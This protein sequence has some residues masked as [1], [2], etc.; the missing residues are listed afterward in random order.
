MQ[1]LGT[2]RTF[3]RGYAL[4]LLTLGALL[5]AWH[6]LSQPPP[7]YAQIPDSGAQR[8]RMIQ[9]LVAANQKLALSVDLLKQIRDNT[10]PPPADRQP[11]RPGDKHP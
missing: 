6:A 1:R 3:W 2:N 11:A 7:A 5:L 9:E 4:G 8:E 10:R